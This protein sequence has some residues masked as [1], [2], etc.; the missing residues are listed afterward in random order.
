MYRFQIPNMPIDPRRGLK[1]ASAWMPS[2]DPPFHGMETCSYVIDLI[3][4][5]HCGWGPYELRRYKKS[6][7]VRYEHPCSMPIE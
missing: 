5:E 3:L 7:L 2:I 4:P 6:G 1:W